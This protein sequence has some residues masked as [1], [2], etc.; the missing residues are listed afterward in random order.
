MWNSS[1]I[2]HNAATYVFGKKKRVQNDWFDNQDE[3][4]RSLLKDKKHNR[5]TPRKRIRELKNNWFQQKAEEAERLS[6]EK[7]IKNCMPP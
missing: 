4:I 1:L 6:Q 2:H 5:N 7:A 3:E